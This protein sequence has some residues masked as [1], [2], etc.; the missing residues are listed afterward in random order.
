MIVGGQTEARAQ[1]SSTIIDYHEPFDQGLK[2]CFTGPAVASNVSKPGSWKQTCTGKLQTILSQ[3]RL[4]K[5]FFHRP[6]S[7][8]QCCMGLGL[9]VHVVQGP[10][11]QAI[12]FTGPAVALRQCCKEQYLQTKFHRTDCCKQ[13]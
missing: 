5:A 11:L 13:T 8:K 1:L 12:R 10:L 3:S 4:L 6:G 2:Q 9:A 7:C